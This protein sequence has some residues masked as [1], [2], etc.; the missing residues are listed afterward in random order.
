MAK[1]SSAEDAMKKS[2]ATAKTTGGAGKKIYGIET[3][4]PY[5][6]DGEVLNDKRVCEEA[7]DALMRS[8]IMLYLRFP[9]Y[10]YLASQLVIVQTDQMPT[11]ATDG[12]NLWYNP[13]FIKSIFMK[14]SKEKAQAHLNF[15][16]THEVEHCVAEHIGGRRQAHR[17][18]IVEDKYGQKISLWNIAVD[19]AVNSTITENVKELAQLDKASRISDAIIRPDMALYDE[20]YKDNTSEEIYD[21]LLE[22]LDKN[23]SISL[24]DGSLLDDHNFGEQVASGEKDGQGDGEG[25]EGDGKGNGKGEGDGEGDF[26]QKPDR[27]S[28]EKKNEYWRSNAEKALVQQKQK[29]D[30][31][32]NLKRLNDILFGEPEINW[33]DRLLNVVTTIEGYKYRMVP[34]NKRH[35]RIMLPSFYGDHVRFNFAIDTSAS[36]DDEKVKDGVSVVKSAACAFES[37]S[38]RF[39]SCDCTVHS[40]KT[41]DVH[42]YDFNSI[43]DEVISEVKGGGGTSFIPVFNLLEEPSD[44]G[45]GETINT[46]LIYFTDGYGDFPKY[47]PDYDVIWVRTPNDLPA[48]SFPFGTVIT[49]NDDAMKK[50]KNYN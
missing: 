29:G 34:P 2:E 40:D 12:L 33:K 46:T 43:K 32:N 23:G 16:L 14:D 7:Y 4:K 28:S 25:Q 3:L 13:Y 49:I 15:I 10:G 38:F 6:K 1:S 8:R 24:G 31:P 35:R 5:L 11:L 45:N 37:A 19:Y 47:P 21:M 44:D 18:V 39:I 26:N 27:K 30:V 17:T 9:F 48:E 42:E 22:E 41:F 50:Q 36:M 20:K